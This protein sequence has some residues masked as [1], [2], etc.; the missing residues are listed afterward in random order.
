MRMREVW[1]RNG[2]SRRRF[3]G[4]LGGMIAGVMALPW[5]V[6]STREEKMAM[7]EADYYRPRGEDE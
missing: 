6:G 1:R 3:L 4:V 7:R 2:H 5:A